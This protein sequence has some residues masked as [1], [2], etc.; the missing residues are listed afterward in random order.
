MRVYLEMIRMAFRRSFSYR[1]DYVLWMLA[2]ALWIVIQLNAWQALFRNQATVDGITLSD[3]ATYIVI[4]MIVTSLN[5]SSI[6]WRLA[7]AV[8]DGSISVSLIRPMNIKLAMMCEELGETFSQTLITVLPIAAAVFAFVGL[9]FPADPLMAVGFAVSVVGGVILSYNIDYVLG[10]LAFWLKDSIY[11]RW[12]LAAF[13]ELFSGTTV[14]LWFYPKPLALVSRYLPFRYVTFE[15]LAMYLG[16]STAVEAV[17]A[18]A[19]QAAWI[20]VFLG[21]GRLTWMRAKRII[22]IHGG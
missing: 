19:I 9:R 7:G 5:R 3:M 11:V 16:K 17:Q 8:Q 18:I 4:A 15:P 2:R 12:F 21:L 6:T 10:L 1:M 20:V 13:Y 22:T 14:P